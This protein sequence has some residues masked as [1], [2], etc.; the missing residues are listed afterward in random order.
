MIYFNGCSFTYGFEL[1]DKHNTRFSKLISDNFG[2]QEWNSSKPGASNERIWRVT[3]SD[4]LLEKP[5]AVVLMW[6]G[7]NRHE[8]LVHVRNKWLW[9][10]GTWKPGYGFDMKTRRCTP[11]SNMSKNVDVPEKQYMYMNGYMK[12]LRNA[13]WNYRY[14]IGYMLSIKYMCKA[15]DIPLFNYTFSR[16]Q[17]VE[18]LDT[19]DWVLWDSTSGEEALADLSSDEVLEELPFL[20]EPGFYD[21]CALHNLKIGPRDHPLEE[22]HEWMADK[23]IKDMKKDAAFKKIIKKTKNRLF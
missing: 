12:E 15:M 7:M 14:T 20:T 10:N 5:K 6:S 18:N 8:Y 21:Y 4:I 2:E 23:I 11:D 13:V 3:M 19:L 17:Y 1:P 22:A 16:T 9:K